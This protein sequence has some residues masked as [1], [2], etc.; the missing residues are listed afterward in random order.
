M[1]PPSLNILR[2]PPPIELP[3]EDSNKK[4]NQVGKLSLCL[5]GTGDA[6]TEWQETLSKHMVGIGFKRGIGHHRVF[7]HGE[8]NVAVLVHGDDYVSEGEKEELDW[9]QER[10]EDRYDLNT[11]RVGRRQIHCVCVA[12][13]S[14]GCVWDAKN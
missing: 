12:V 3:T 8:R 6:A 5:Y 9:L 7:Y 13:V 1:A 10:L 11:Q 2:F 4:D 14:Q